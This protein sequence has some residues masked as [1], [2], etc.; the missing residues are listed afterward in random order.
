MAAAT[1]TYERRGKDL[2]P[3]ARLPFRVGI[4]RV[5]VP[6]DLAAKM[7]TLE[8]APAEAERLDLEAF[9]SRAISTLAQIELGSR[10]DLPDGTWLA[11]GFGMFHAHNRVTRARGL[12]LRRQFDQARF[13]PPL[14]ELLSATGD[15]DEQAERDLV[16]LIRCAR[17]RRLEAFIH[18]SGASTT[19]FA[20]VR[21]ADDPA[22]ISYRARLLVQPFEVAQWS[23]SFL[24]VGAG[25]EH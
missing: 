10:D 1:H 3:D 7:R 4:T 23:D 22:R 8:R 14:A 25:R 12:V 17:G 13:S 21:A 24:E 2:G 20:I 19:A 6:P 9:Q 11:A 15:R 5:P 16:G 18:V